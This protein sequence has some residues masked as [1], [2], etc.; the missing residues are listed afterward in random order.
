VDEVGQFI[1]TDSHLML[2][3]QTITEE[4][5]TVCRRRAWVVVTSQED[6]DAARLGEA[7]LPRAVR[8]R[9]YL[10]VLM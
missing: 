9:R 8:C 1:G 10:R 6:M 4:L 3:L 5:G 7:L 2:N